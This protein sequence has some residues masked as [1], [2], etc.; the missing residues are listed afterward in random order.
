[1]E[2]VRHAIFQHGRRVIRALLQNCHSRL[3]KYRQRIDQE[4][5]RWCEFISK[6]GAK[7]I[8]RRAAER[9]REQKATREAVLENK[10][11]KLPNPTSSKNDKLVYD[12]SSNELTEEQMQVLRHGASVNTVDAKP[13]NMIAA[14]GSIL[15]RTETTYK[16]QNLI[17]HQVS[18]LLLAHRPHNVLPKAERDA[19]KE[20]RADSDLFIVPAEKGR[21]TAVLDRTDYIQKAKNLLE[22]R[23]SIELLLQDKCDERGND[24]GHA[25]IFQFLKFRLK[26]Y[27]TFDGTMYEQVKVTPVGSPISGH[28]DEAVL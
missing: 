4:K 11:R 21:S 2:L 3:R 5:A 9:T 18:S 16:T 7:L 28:I 24:L 27:F 12:L 1:M 15:N 8:Q 14:V 6:S 22:D 20:L 26:T 17:R 23:Q 13:A 10:F 19:L 25:Q